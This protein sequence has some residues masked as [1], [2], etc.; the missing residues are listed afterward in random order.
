[1]GE[2]DDCDLVSTSFI[3]KSGGEEDE[4]DKQSCE[5]NNKYA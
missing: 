4:E 5:S 2:L 1:M 3:V